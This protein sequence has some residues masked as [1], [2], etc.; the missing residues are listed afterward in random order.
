MNTLTVGSPAP[1]IRGVKW[2]NSAPIDKLEPGHV[3]IVE[4]WA[5]WCGPCR[6]GMPH[7]SELSA[8]LAGRATVIGVNVFEQDQGSAA[9]IQNVG[10]FI[11]KMGP[12]LTYPVL[13][14][15]ADKYMAE[16]WMQRSGRQGIPSAFVVDQ[17]GFVVWIGHPMQ[18]MDG[19]V[20]DVL[21]GRTPAIPEENESER[22][23][24]K[25]QQMIAPFMGAIQQGDYDAALREIDRLVANGGPLKQAE[26]GLR[27]QAAAM[28]GRDDIARQTLMEVW[29][30]P[31]N[32]RWLSVAHI[33]AI[34]PRL[35][36]G[37]Y[38]L[39]IKIVER[40]MAAGGE[41]FDK[42]RFIHLDA[43]AKIY[44]LAGDRER[45]IEIEHEAISEC[46]KSPEMGARFKPQCEM[47]LEHIEQQS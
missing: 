17:K 30:S 24:K 39:G 1:E 23:L 40:G 29:E 7:L 35:S 44:F 13:V 28:C 33:L 45:A 2:F 26:D 47:F 41:E 10:D 21:Q 14:D 34:S 3:Y 16:A 5:T 27:F 8:K 31:G 42:Y 4:F 37:S 19:A 36:L 20:E 43:L 18:G 22:D 11:E 38:R 46:D 25:Q 6:A 15:A 9:C 32:E 12:R